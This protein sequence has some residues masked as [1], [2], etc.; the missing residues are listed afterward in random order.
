MSTR[1]LVV[2]VV[3]GVTRWCAVQENEALQKE[4]RALHA[5]VGASKRMYAAGEAQ[6]QDQIATIS[7]RG[8]GL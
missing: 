6:V 2:V 5:A 7:V 4:N 3:D 1:G 8:V